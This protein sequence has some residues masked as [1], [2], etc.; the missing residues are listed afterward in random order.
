MGVGL[1]NTFSKKFTF[2]VAF[3]MS[4]IGASASEINVSDV[5]SL[6]EAAKNA[7]AGDTVWIAPGDYAFTSSIRSDDTFNHLGQDNGYLWIGANGTKDNPIVFAGSDPSNPPVLKGPGYSDYGIHVTGDFVILKNL[8]IK[9]FGKAVMVDHAN[10]VIIEDCH[11][12]DTGTEIVHVRD[13]SQRVI[14]NRNL[15]HGSGSH[16]GK[17]G[18]GVYVGSY[19]GSWASSLASEKSAGYWGAGVSEYRKSNYDWRVNDT[20]I[21]C[22]VIK[23]T[24]AENIDVKEGTVGGLIQGNMF[25]A[26]WLATEADAPDYDDAYIDMKGVKWVVSGNYMYDAKNTSLPYYN[27]KFKYFVEEVTSRSSHSNIGK[28]E[29][30]VGYTVCAD[31][32]AQNG[33]CDNSA[34]DQNQCFEAENS[35]V[36]EIKDVRNDCEELFKI[37]SAPITYSNTDFDA[38]DVNK[39]GGETPSSSSSSNSGNSSTST[40]TKLE[41]YEAELA[42]NTD[43]VKQ[44]H[45]DASGGYYL[46]TKKE[47]VITFNVNVPTADTYKVIF[48]YN[49]SANNTKTQDIYVNNVKVKSQEFPVTIEGN[50]GGA[51]AAFES[52]EIPLSLKAGANTISIKPSWGYVDIDYI[53]VPVPETGSTT[54][55]SEVYEAELATNTDCIKQAHA[56]A[57]GGYYLLTKKEGVITFNVNVPK[58]DTYKVTFRYNNTASNAKTQDIYVNDVKVKSQSFPVTLE[59]DLGGAA[60]AF[61]SLEIPLSLKAGA[62][63]ISIK[64]SWGYVDIDYISIPVPESGS[65]KSLNIV[66][67]VNLKTE[68]Q[69]KNI[70]VHTSSLKTNFTLLDLQGRIVK[71]GTL[72]AGNTIISVGNSGFYLLKV[73]NLL[74]KIQIK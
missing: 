38:L 53:A 40:S 29:T 57:S 50:L 74:R 62:N 48:R 5:S 28:Y 6:I 72:N 43:C 13:S 56:E 20:K 64:P 16:T 23:A 46:L 10:D 63:T 3:L 24:T 25:V 26:D 68:I 71:T 55:K 42:T 37:P 35:I 49:N 30:A 19:P 33:W 11:I 17:Y 32:Y 60:A 51:A 18:E 14:I 8:E 1:K 58:A 34:K 47:G 21:T 31:S 9:T 67:N 70:V 4:S 52:L 22:N 2:G 65:S 36:N 27:P 44:S 39:L 12:H 45:A 69:G 66:L 61:E 54:I 59:G 41:V 73:G 15:I 7:K